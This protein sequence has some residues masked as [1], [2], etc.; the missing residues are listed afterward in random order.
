MIFNKTRRQKSQKKV[1]FHA[2]KQ[3]IMEKLAA[4]TFVEE[5]EER[6]SKATSIRDEDI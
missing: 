2:Q 6:L 3:K 4:A 5:F 1:L